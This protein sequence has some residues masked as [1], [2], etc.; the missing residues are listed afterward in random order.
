MA[1]AP[2]SSRSV[3]SNPADPAQF[4]I[5]ETFSVPGVGTVVSGTTIAGTITIGDSLMMGMLVVL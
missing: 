1:I 5:D 4:Q 3:P 2:H